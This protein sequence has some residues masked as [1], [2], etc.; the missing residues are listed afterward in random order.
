[1]LFINVFATVIDLLIYA[2]CTI[3]IIKN[4]V[5]TIPTV[6]TLETSTSNYKHRYTFI[7]NNYTQNYRELCKRYSKQFVFVF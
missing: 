1:M 6:K 5:L 2:S 3:E 7:S 4:L